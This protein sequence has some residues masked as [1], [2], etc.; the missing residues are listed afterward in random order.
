MDRPRARTE[1]L[2]T[3]HLDGELL[4]Y[5]EANDVACRLNPT[6]ALVWQSCDGSRSVSDLV[7]IVAAEHGDVADQDMVLMALDTLHEHGLIASGY[8]PREATA[9]LLSRRRFFRRVGV[10]SAAAVAAPIVYS[11][12]VPAAAA[13][14]S[15]PYTPYY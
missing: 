1:G 6:A 10:T 7:A 14:Q 2:L 15:T 13:A 11:M 12:T 5:D 8:A 4:V 3:E 9:S